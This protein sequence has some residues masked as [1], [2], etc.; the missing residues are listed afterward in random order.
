MSL[1]LTAAVNSNYTRV[2]GLEY[3]TAQIG[4]VEVEEVVAKRRVFG[5]SDLA[6][7]GVLGLNADSI[8]WN[9]FTNTLQSKVPAVG[10]K[11]IDS[12][13]VTW[14]IGTVDKRAWGSRYR[15]ICARART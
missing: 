2:N 5:F 8:V 9:L 13:D 6:F 12:T 10:D 11:I 1:S 4:G 15:C 7:A 3:I 14:I